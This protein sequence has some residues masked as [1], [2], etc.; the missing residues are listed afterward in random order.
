MPHILKC[1]FYLLA[2]KY[3]SNSFHLLTLYKDH[4]IK[5]FFLLKLKR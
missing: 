5:K 1:Y 4:T 3:V 2:K